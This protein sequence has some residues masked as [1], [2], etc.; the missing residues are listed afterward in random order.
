MA[1]GVVFL[2]EEGD[3]DGDEG[4]EDFG[5]CWVPAAGFD[6]EFESDIVDGEVNGDYEDIA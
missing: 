4:D 6:K 5:G 2:S 1:E 3:G